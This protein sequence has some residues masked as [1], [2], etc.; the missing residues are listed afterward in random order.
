MRHVLVGALGEDEDSVGYTPLDIDFLNDPLLTLLTSTIAV[1]LEISHGDLENSF[2]VIYSY[3]CIS[4]VSSITR[5]I[6]DRMLEACSAAHGA[7]YELSCS[8][9]S[10][11]SSQKSTPIRPSPTVAS[12]RS[13]R[14]S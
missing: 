10:S 11:S 8:I 4:T 13:S 3:T 2:N 6:H 1:V 12:L 7:F 9:T 14:S 5:F